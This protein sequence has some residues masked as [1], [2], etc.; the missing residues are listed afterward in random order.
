MISV[1]GYFEGG[2]LPVRSLKIIF[3]LA[4]CI[5]VLNDYVTQHFISVIV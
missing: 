1:K 2:C 5:T 4:V 3:A